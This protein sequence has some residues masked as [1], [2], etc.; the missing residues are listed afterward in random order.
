[1]PA[2]RGRCRAHSL[3][4][5]AVSPELPRRSGLPRGDALRGRELAR[6]RRRGAAPARRVARTTRDRAAT[7]KTG[8]ASATSRSWRSTASTSRSAPR[9]IASSAR[10]RPAP[11][12]SPPTCPSSSIA[13]YPECRG[14]RVGSL[15]L[16]TIVSRARAVG[17]HAI[18]LSVAADNPA[19][20]LYARHGF[21]V[22]AATSARAPSDDRL[23]G[24]VSRWSSSS[25]D[26]AGRARIRHESA[27][28]AGERGRPAESMQP[29]PTASPSTFIGPAP[30]ATLRAPHTNGAVDDIG[31]REAPVHPPPGPP[32]RRRGVRG[33]VGVRAHLFGDRRRTVSR[34]PRRPDGPSSSQLASTRSTRCTAL[35]QVGTHAA[36]RPEAARISHEDAILA[37]MVERL[38]RLAS[39]SRRLR[40]PR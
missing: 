19:R 14:Q 30:E 13:V 4:I 37:A 9:G 10:R 31:K 29:C 32:R 12:S 22:V 15:L 6:R 17:Y 24:G 28:P 23:A 36:A 40:P 11:A 27:A 3:P 2:E 26:R 18:S 7:S 21:E 34:T 20:R 1:M 8:D 39:R 35:P 5:P 25:T 33:P 16:G 38:R